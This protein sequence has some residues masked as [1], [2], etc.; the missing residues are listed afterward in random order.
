MFGRSIFSG[1]NHLG[2]KRGAKRV[3]CFFARRKPAVQLQISHLDDLLGTDV[4]ITR[5]SSII[6]DDHG[7]RLTTRRTRTTSGNFSRKATALHVL[8]SRNPRKPYY[9]Q[10]YLPRRSADKL[11]YSTLLQKWTNNLII[12][13]YDIH[14]I[15][16]VWSAVEVVLKIAIVIFVI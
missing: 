16:Y 8:N 1:F 2:A 3:S 5:G 4:Y 9:R 10:C 12:N 6:W 13:Y 14:V 11:S 15:L 7:A